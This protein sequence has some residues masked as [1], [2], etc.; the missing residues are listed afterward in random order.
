MYCSHLSILKNTL[1]DEKIKKLKE[2]FAALTPN[3]KSYIM[4]SKIMRVLEI[5]YEESVKVLLSLENSGILERY[6]GVRCPECSMLIRTGN[7]I[8]ELG[9]ENIDICYS[10]DEKINITKKDIV[11]IFRIKGDISPFNGGQQEGSFYMPNKK[12]SFAAPEDSYE[13]FQ[14]YENSLKI[15]AL[16]AKEEME[17]RNEKKL[18]AELDKEYEKRAISLYKRNIIVSVILSVFGYVFLVLLIIYVYWK[19]GFGKIS[20]FATFGSSLI[21]FGVNYIIVKIF[22]QDIELIKRILRSE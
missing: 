15:L 7:S 13:L 4:P 6:Y 9:L 10:C 16:N 18:N 17:E 5:N 14:S 3:T 12:N 8:E 11:I 2:Y 21:P 20:I 19:Y 22:P 1:S